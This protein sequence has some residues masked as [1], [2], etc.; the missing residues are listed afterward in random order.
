MT[1]APAAD[2]YDDH[3]PWFHLL[4]PPGDYAEEAAFTIELMR[5]HISG[6][7]ETMLELGAGGGNVA[8]HLKDQVRLTLTDLSPAMVEVSHG[9]NPECEH[10]VGDMR[11]LRLARQFDVVA[12]LPDYVRETFTPGT[13]AGL[14]AESDR[15]QMGPGCLHR[16]AG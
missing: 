5:R 11:T 12:V 8:S 3:A 16:E 4:T 13:D 2:I 10:L 14:N 1:D 7:L 6:P 9:L 15:D